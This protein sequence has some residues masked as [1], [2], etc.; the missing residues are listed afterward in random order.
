M[1]RLG[2]K[3]MKRTFVITDVV[4]ATVFCTKEDVDS[5]IIDDTLELPDHESSL[6]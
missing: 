3:K 5:L 2:L 6:H 1:S 4:F